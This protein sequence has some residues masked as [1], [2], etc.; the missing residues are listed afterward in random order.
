M[1]RPEIPHL[2]VKF[3]V[4]MPD[5]ETDHPSNHGIPS[6][7]A[8]G[9]NAYREEKATYDEPAKEQCRAYCSRWLSALIR[10][11]AY[12]CLQPQLPQASKTWKCSELEAATRSPRRNPAVSQSWDASWAFRTHA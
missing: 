6:C 7:L 5:D 3:N 4:A 2:L 10:V 12:L 8:C 11:P 9:R 1:D